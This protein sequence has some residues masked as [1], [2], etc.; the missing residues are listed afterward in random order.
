ML[1]QVRLSQQ[2]FSKQE[3][4]DRKSSEPAWWPR[5]HSA[6]LWKSLRIFRLWCCVFCRSG[7]PVTRITVRTFVSFSEDETHTW[8]M[9]TELA[10]WFFLCGR[11]SS[12]SQLRSFCISDQRV[13]MEGE[14]ERAMECAVSLRYSR[15]WWRDGNE[16]INIA[17]TAVGVPVLDHARLSSLLFHS[18][19]QQ[20]HIY[21]CPSSI[22]T[23]GAK[24]GILNALK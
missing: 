21:H 3:A 1:K 18:S 8:L 13:E 23:S 9:L 5:P 12:D 2:T 15:A 20:K 10:V 17:W 24:S 4:H 19:G 16:I 11:E 14:R 6:Q 7:F 22:L